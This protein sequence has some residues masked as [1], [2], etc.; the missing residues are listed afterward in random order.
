[1]SPII[2]SRMAIAVRFRSS[3]ATLIR[4]TW[5]QSVSCPWR[6]ESLAELVRVFHGLKVTEAR[7]LHE[8]RLVESNESTD[9][10]KNPPPGAKFVQDSI[11]KK[12]LTGI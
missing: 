1:M 9:R 11:R 2:L 3:A 7:N 4:T 10:V 12:R 8:K 5:M 6:T